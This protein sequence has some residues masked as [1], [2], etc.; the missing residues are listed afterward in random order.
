MFSRC[1]RI[2]QILGIRRLSN[3]KYPPHTVIRMP[4]LSPTMTKG[5]LAQWRKR[6]GDQV[7]TGDVLAEVETD[8]ATM[9]FEAAEDGYVA[10][11]LVDDGT[12]DVLV[13]Q[14]QIFIVCQKYFSPTQNTH[15]RWQC[16]V[17]KRLMWPSL[18]ISR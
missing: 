7:T 12:K 5:N 18:K 15:S 10:R 11:I 2:R 9:E 16:F 3:A 17:R 4:A 14:V 1:L 13:S 8:K 6:L